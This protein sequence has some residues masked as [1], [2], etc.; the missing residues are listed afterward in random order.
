MELINTFV[1]AIKHTQAISHLNRSLLKIL[2]CT[3]T[4][5]YSMFGKTSEAKQF[6]RSMPG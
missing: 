5:E 1:S 2:Y 4:V 6:D 3:C